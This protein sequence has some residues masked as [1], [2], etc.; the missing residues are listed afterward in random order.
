MTHI[1]EGTD[2]GNGCYVL[3]HVVNQEQLEIELSR[4][5][6]SDYVF[7]HANFAN[8]FAQESDHSLSISEDQ[9]R[10]IPAKHVVFSHEHIGRIE[11]AGK[12]VIVG[13]ARPSSISDCLG[14]A[15][16]RVMRITDNGYEF[17]ETWRAA[18]DYIELPWQE[19]RDTGE[20][21]IRVVGN[22]S[23]DEAVQVATAI[24][25]FRASSP[26]RVISNAVKIE[27]VDD[28]EQLTLSH[29]AITAFN[30]REALRELLTDEE[31]IKIDKLKEA[32]H[33]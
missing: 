20:R 17:I 22:A 3:P 26:A 23:A 18:G 27:G 8:V 24:S 19:L 16:K 7:V 5:P 2:I 32:H 28:A 29:E 15:S 9:A 25:K 11:M 10:A 1:V 6:V 13:N 21:F 30:V 4:I 31:N 33:A 12:V 14:N